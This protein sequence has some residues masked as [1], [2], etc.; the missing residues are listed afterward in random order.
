[1]P[2]F[3]NGYQ[4]KALPEGTPNPPPPPK[5]GS[6]ASR[7]RSRT[8]LLQDEELELIVGKADRL[9]E[10]MAYERYKEFVGQNP[11]VAEIMIELFIRDPH[12][13]RLVK[14]MWNKGYA[15]GFV[16]ATHAAVMERNEQ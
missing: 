16:A 14:T 5:G 7:C 8:M 2:S 6:G 12:T 15:C 1:M 3:P 4:P 9:M 10:D 11:I 13:E